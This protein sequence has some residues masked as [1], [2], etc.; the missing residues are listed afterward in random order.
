MNL[1]QALLHEKTIVATIA[2]F[3]AATFLF[4]LTSRIV[5]YIDHSPA[6]HWWFK[7]FSHWY[8]EHVWIPVIRIITLIIFISLAYPII[9]GLKAAPPLADILW[10]K[11][12]LNTLINVTFFITLVLPLIPIIG[13]LHA[14]VLPIQGCTIVIVFFNW[15]MPFYNVNMTS[16]W[17]GGLQAVLLFAL[18][19][20]SHWLAVRSAEYIGSQLDDWHN[21]QG[22]SQIIYQLTLLLF[23]API[24]LLYSLHLGRQ[25]VT[26]SFS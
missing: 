3:V 16:Y 5:H 17:P 22:Y 13:N 15:L 19:I 4:I 18:I 6:E 25:L 7:I 21:R 10:Q 9:F 11:G 1:W 12:H 20:P 2:Y 24:I 23:Q 8:V 14:L 26:T